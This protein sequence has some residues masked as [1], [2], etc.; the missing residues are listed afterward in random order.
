M[1]LKNEKASGPDKIP[2]EAIKAD[3]ATAVNILH[4]LF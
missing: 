1:T 2:A 4:S 3:I